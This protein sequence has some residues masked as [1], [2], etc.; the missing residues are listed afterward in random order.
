MSCHIT[1]R[2]VIALTIPLITAVFSLL[3]SN[4]SPSDEISGSLVMRNHLTSSKAVR[5]TS[6]FPLG[7]APLFLFTL[8]LCTLRNSAVARTFML[9]MSAEGDTV[10]QTARARATSDSDLAPRASLRDSSAVDGSD[11]WFESIPDADEL[12]LMSKLES[13][14]LSGKRLSRVVWAHSPVLWLYLDSSK[15]S[16]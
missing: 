8:M 1:S 13:H 3:L 16:H 15:T 5:V 6:V 10:S 2:H 12:A 9:F 7:L 4:S 11:S 14:F